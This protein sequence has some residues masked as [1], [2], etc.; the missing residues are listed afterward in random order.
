[1]FAIY[2][3]PETPSR[4]ATPVTYTLSYRTLGLRPPE[5]RLS[6]QELGYLSFVVPNRRIGERDRQF[7]DPS[8]HHGQHLMIPGL[9][10]VVVE[11]P[12][13]QAVL[14]LFSFERPVE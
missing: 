11:Y 14:K 10:S 8:K 2:Y 4:G 7:R 3:S 5:V 6:G 13:W 1:M 12:C 9:D